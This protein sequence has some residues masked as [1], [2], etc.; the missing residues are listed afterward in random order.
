[1]KDRE[2]YGKSNEWSIAQRLEKSQYPGVNEAI[3]QPAIA[4]SV[5]WYG[6]VLRA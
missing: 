6:H 3:G 2:I 5:H 1:M 4:S